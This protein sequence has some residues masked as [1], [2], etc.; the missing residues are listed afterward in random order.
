MDVVRAGQGPVM[1]VALHGIQGT[2]ASWMPVAQALGSQCT[3]VLPNL[4]GRGNAPPPP[5]RDACTLDSYARM[6]RDVIDAETGGRPFVLAGWSMG[7]SVALAYAARCMSEPR[8]HA[9]CGLAL[10]SG[11]PRLDAVAW[12]RATDETVL[13][14][15]IAERERRLGLAEAA[16]HTTVAWTWQ[17]LRGTDQRGLLPRIALPALVLHGERDEDCP[18][19]HARTLAAGLP[20]AT[21]AML[22]DAGHGILSTHTR[23]VAEAFAARLPHLCPVARAGSIAHQ[24]SQ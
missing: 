15:E 16:D 18:A 8:L 22:A 9:P 5:A 10:L 14:R 4:W 3:F 11:T 23:Q 21:L 20:N 2:R 17:A 19:A 6:L 7:V 12:F 1:V 24:E 13:L